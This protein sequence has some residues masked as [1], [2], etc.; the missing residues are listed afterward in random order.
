[1]V[2]LNTPIDIPIDIPM[3]IPITI[4]TH[5]LHTTP[6]TSTSTPSTS[7]SANFDGGWLWE[8]VKFGV[9]M[10]G[11]FYFAHKTLALM[12][13]IV[14][15]AN[16]AAASAAVAKRALAKRLNRPEIETMTFDEYESRLL[17]DIMSPDEI[18]VG[19]VDIGGMEAEL[20]EIGD[21]VVLPMKMW[22]RFGNLG[23]LPPCPTGVL[24]YGAPGTGKS[25][26]AKAIAKESGATFLNLKA[27]SIMDK[28]LGETDKMVSAIFRLGRKLAPAVLFIDEIETVLKK[29]ESGPF[30]NAGLQS[31]QG[32]FLSEWD[33][34]TQDNKDLGETG[35]GTQSA[36]G[37]VLLLGATNRPQDLDKAFLRR[38]PVQIQT[39]MP[40]TQ[41]RAAILRAQL[42]SQVLSP[43]VDLSVLA[44]AIPAFSGSDIRELVRLAMQQRAK[45]YPLCTINVY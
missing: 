45:V 25:L 41:A 29:R 12:A 27:S 7:I 8:V 23:D 31:M 39:P 43:D 20:E 32:V 1:M 33:G 15:P 40:D 19:F 3:D 28:Y 42:Q 5:T 18:G 16:K 17:P 22:R 24:L 21:T 44:A 10:A 9:V 2:E 14:E 26:T 13:A 35:K 38:M 11:S 36:Q 34:L 30:A 6:S 4:T 37:P